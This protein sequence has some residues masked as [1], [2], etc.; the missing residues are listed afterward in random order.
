MYGGRDETCPVSTEGGTRRV[1]L[2][3][4][5]GE[6]VFHHDDRDC[7]E[8]PLLIIVVS[9]TAQARH[10]S[11]L[12]RAGVLRIRAGKHATDPRPLD[13][14]CTCATCAQVRAP[15]SALHPRGVSDR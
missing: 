2:V 7:G 11:V 12:T 15:L 13:E 5:R 3:R 6:G 8:R 4:D 14:Q 1:Q 10:G 9:V